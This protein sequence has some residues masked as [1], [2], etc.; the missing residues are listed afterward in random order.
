MDLIRQDGTYFVE[1]LEQQGCILLCGSLRMQ[2]DVE[3]T[4]NEILLVSTGKSINIYKEKGQI[5]TDCY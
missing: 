1:L 2:Q 3:A 5:L 4:L